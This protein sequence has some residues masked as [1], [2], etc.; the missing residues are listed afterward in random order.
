MCQQKT[1]L[2]VTTWSFLVSRL[3]IF[4]LSITREKVMVCGF[5][6]W[7]LD[8]K[9]RHPTLRLV[10]LGCSKEIKKENKKKEEKKY[11]P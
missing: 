5:V 3:V 1:R 7:G 2:A 11:K 4:W 9:I 8:M 10:E 6:V